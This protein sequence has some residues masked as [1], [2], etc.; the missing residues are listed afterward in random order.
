MIIERLREAE[1]VAAA[2]LAEATLS[3]EMTIRRDLDQLA[4]QGVLRRVRGGAVS[5]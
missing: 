4:E 2:E 5:L 3:S 1:R